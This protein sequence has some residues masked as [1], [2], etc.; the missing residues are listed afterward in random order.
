MEDSKISPFTEVPTVFMK[1]S[2]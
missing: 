2:G 1:L